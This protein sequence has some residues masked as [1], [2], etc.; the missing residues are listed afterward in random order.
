MDLLEILFERMPMGIVV[1][2]RELK[3]VRCNPTWAEFIERYTPSQASDVLPGKT[4]AEL[5]PGAEIF[6]MTAVER[7]L[8]GETVYVEAMRSVSG[9]IESFWDV[10]FSPLYQNGKVVGILDV[11]TDAT[12]RVQVLR[13]LENRVEERTREVEHRRKIAES[14]RDII[15]MIN[16]HMPLNEF[17]QRAVKLAAGQLG[18]GGC[19][20]HHL[21]L[22]NEII[23]HIASY[24][25]EDIFEKR[26][27]RPF[28]ALRP[29]GGEAYLQA[30]LNRQPTYRNYPPMPERLGEIQR[31][32][33]IPEA[34]KRER[35]ALRKKFAGSLSVP[36][37]IQDRLYGGMVFYYTENQDFDE[38]QIQLGLIF[39]EQMAVA[40]ENARLF[41]DTEQRRN[42]AESLSEILEVLNSTQTPQEIFNFL[43]KRSAALLAADACLLYRLDN[44]FVIQESEYNLPPELA[45][46]K[47]GKLYPGKNNLDLIN[48]QPVVIHDA[49]N[50]LSQ[51]LAQ[52]DLNAF[53]SNWYQGVQNNFKAYLGIPLTVN[54]KLFGGLVFY[55]KNPHRFTEEDV[56]LASSL[57]AHSV[58][59][60][61][62]ARLFQEAERRRNV[63]ESLRETL[64]ILNIE[65]PLEE[66]LQHIVSQ[67]QV[68]LQA[69]AVAIHQL[70]VKDGLLKP[71]ATIGLS[72]EY[73]A[74]IR[75]PVGQGAL[76]QAVVTRNPVAVNDTSQVFAG[77]QARAADGQ[78]INLDSDLL[79]KLQNFSDRYGAILAVP[80]TVKTQVYGGL[81]LYYATP[82]TIQPEEIQLAVTFANQASLAI[83][84]AMLRTQAAEA[85]A[86][87]ERN[88]LARDLHD[89]VSQTLFSASLIA[90][91]LP[92]LWQRNPDAAQQKLNELGQLTR[93]ALSEMR[94][95]LLELRPASLGDIDLSDLLRHLVNAFIG[96]MRTTAVLEACGF[97]ANGVAHKSW[98]T[99]L[100]VVAQAKIKSRQ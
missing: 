35:I 63:A 22:E 15:G 95:L 58:L 61:E 96:R 4:L 59:A 69:K 84:N 32:A 67:A 50:Y 55:Y 42:V 100:L 41:Q 77:Q 2:D 53:Q 7:V 6:F 62:N 85:A 40:I 66:I 80:M 14:M 11:T 26:G 19:V 78:A 79:T 75:L 65:R 73:V 1:F 87:S 34:L 30:L 23:T 10:A 18:A 29:S 31:D 51:I 20:L 98:L 45:N 72:P 43:T 92:K 52:P 94:T 93:G 5:A 86:L 25:M 12:E 74:N 88:R 70:D 21:D 47:T 39:A 49:T 16:S 8:Q 76:G 36:L 71:Q 57:G 83:E 46:L 3:I 89:A 48:L 91:V 99:L 54:E 90:D 64:S 9:G 68:V 28:S 44:E 17:L 37:Y 60:I 24:G 33:S 13:N 38:E 82:R 56:R 97:N 27:S 81:A